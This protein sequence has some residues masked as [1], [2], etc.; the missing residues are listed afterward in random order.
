[1]AG[2]SICQVK[3][4]PVLVSIAD[5]RQGIATG[6]VEIMKLLGW[7]QVPSLFLSCTG[8]ITQ[9]Q[10]NRLNTQSLASIMFA[11]V[12]SCPCTKTGQPNDTSHLHIQV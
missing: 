1:M 9:L 4:Y 5:S 7:L 2:V 12:S 6:L 11:P 8:A 3:P 10:H